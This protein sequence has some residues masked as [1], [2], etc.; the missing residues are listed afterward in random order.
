MRRF[1]MIC[2]LL[3]AYSFPAF[4]VSQLVGCA[5]TREAGDMRRAIAKIHY[6]I[7][8][9]KDWPIQRQMC[10]DESRAFC[11]T[12]GFNPDCAIDR[13]EDDKRP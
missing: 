10:V 1:L 6:C 2:G 4:V 7:L 12:H 13:F 9:V 11:T 5:S 3:A 8:S